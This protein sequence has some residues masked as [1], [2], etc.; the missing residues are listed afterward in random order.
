MIED[1]LSEQAATGRLTFE[2]LEGRL[3]NLARA[4]TR[5]EA[6]PLFDGLPASSCPSWLSAPPSD[7]TTDKPVPGAAREARSTGTS[8]EVL[9]PSRP[10]ARATR[11]SKPTR[12]LTSRRRPAATSAQSCRPSTG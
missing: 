8:D 11:S 2:E 4:Q 6:R 9:L 12:L 1:A 5:G 10:A 7:A 3:D